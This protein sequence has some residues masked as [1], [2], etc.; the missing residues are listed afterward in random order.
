MTQDY[1]TGLPSDP[2]GSTTQT[3]KDQAAGVAQSAAQSGA[4]LV[5]EAKTQAGQVGREAGRQAKG[6]LDQG[7]SQLA[8]QASQQQTKLAGGIRSFGDELHSLAQGS[9]QPGMA[10]D[11]AQQVASRADSVAQWLEGREPGD[12]LQELKGFARS[13][14]GTFL[15]VAAG[16]GLLAGRLT[17]GIRDASS[18]ETS[19][20]GGTHR[21]P[22]AAS[23]GLEAG[24]TYGTPT[25]EP[26]TYGTGAVYGETT[27]TGTGAEY[28]AG[29][30]TATG[31]Y[32]ESASTLG[33]AGGTPTYGLEQADYGTQGEFGTGNSYATSDYTSA[34]APMT[35]GSSE[36]TMVYPAAGTGTYGGGTENP[37]QTAAYGTEDPGVFGGGTTEVPEREAEI[38]TAWPPVHGEG[39]QR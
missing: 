8:D 16:A 39:D 28:A 24:P 2:Q 11:I 12:L 21:L 27:S 26:S 15:A 4:Q 5:G 3:A 22:G 14:P 25:Y 10:S 19:T 7:R 13:R 18:D 1:Q 20:G 34:G 29:A 30:G 38:D 31:L 23:T 32:Q 35:S 17:R 33:T 36:D 9:P 6:I 37:E